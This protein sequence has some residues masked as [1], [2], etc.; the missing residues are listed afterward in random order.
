MR[1]ALSFLLPNLVVRFSSRHSMYFQWVATHI[2]LNGIEIADKLATADTLRANTCL[3]FAELSSILRI[4]L[5]ALWRIPPLTLRILGEI[6]VS[7]INLIFLGINRLLYHTFLVATSNLLL[8]NRAGKSFQS[9]KG[10]GMI[11]PPPVI[12]LIA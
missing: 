12:F 4:E 11:R 9:F 5:N 7:I 1:E 3:T 6:F 8:F 10:A 2:R